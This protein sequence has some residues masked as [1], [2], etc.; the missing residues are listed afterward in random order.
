M[1]AARPPSGLTEALRHYRAE[2]A[3]L[4]AIPPSSIFSNKV[5]VSIVN[6]RPTTLGSL[7]GLRGIGPVRCGNYGAD[8][9]RLVNLDAKRRGR[10]GSKRPA[11][12]PAARAKAAK[13]KGRRITK[14]R[15]E[16]SAPKKAANKKR[17]VSSKFFMS[18]AESKAPK[19]VTS[20]F[21]PPSQPPEAVTAIP[22][23]PPRLPP[24]PK[25]SVYILELEDGRVY[26]GSSRDVPRRVSQHASGS[27]SAYTRVY[28]PTGVLL[29]RLGNVEGDGDAAERDET[30]RY[31]M[32]RGIPF[33]RG[34][35]FARVDMT[36]EE[37]VEAE[38][39]IRE[40]F[41]L[42]RKCGYKGHFCTH[43]KATFDRLG[44]QIGR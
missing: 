7:R 30:L 44:N 20:R 19:I 41:D 21:F 42:C 28:R 25:T 24:C 33:V 15:Q 37:F 27:G 9:V 13:S 26:V 34:W 38:S 6:S 31:M 36:G 39:N 11:K 16:A 5:L 35:K 3:Y 32:L 29:P 12:V 23:I 40:L 43:C 14:G 17:P 2:Q 22:L 1:V 8:I 18:D 4:R 10:G